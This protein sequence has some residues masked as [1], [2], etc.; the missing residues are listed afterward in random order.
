MLPLYKLKSMSA[1][2]QC[3]TSALGGHADE[4]DSCGHIR[5]SYNSCRN[6][7]CPKCQSFAKEEWIENRKKELLP[8]TYFHIVFTIPDSLNR[9]TLVN[10][11]VIYEIKSEYNP[12]YINGRCG[13]IYLKGKKIGEIGEIHPEVLLNFKLEFPVAALELNFQQLFNEMQI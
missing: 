5:I 4:C 3:R 10:Q 1:I 12:S 8:I 11:K 7:H 13:T 2:E 9:I 6:R